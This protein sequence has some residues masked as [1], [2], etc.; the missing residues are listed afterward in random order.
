MLLRR[1]VQPLTKKTGQK[2]STPREKE[3]RKKMIAQLLLIL[4]GCLLLH[5]STLAVAL[6]G[7]LRPAILIPPGQEVGLA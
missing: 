7:A 4:A 5:A 3:V 6:A 1:A 2:R